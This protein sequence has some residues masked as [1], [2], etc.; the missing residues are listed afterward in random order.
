MAKWDLPRW[1]SGKRLE[2]LLITKTWTKP[3][4]K[5]SVISVTKLG[6]GGYQ[7]Q[8]KVPMIPL[9]A[10]RMA[11]LFH[12]SCPRISSTV[13]SLSGSILGFCSSLGNA[14][15]SASDGAAMSRDRPRKESP[16]WNT[17]GGGR[18]RGGT[19]RV[20]VARRRRRRSGGGRRSWS[21]AGLRGG[22]GSRRKNDGKEKLS[23]DYFNPIPCSCHRDTTVFFSWQLSS[24]PLQLLLIKSKRYYWSKY[25]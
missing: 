9:K 20:Q 12:I 10:L 11:Q 21:A 15:G 1:T 4:T 6:P 2:G 3:Y 22:E 19:G 24:F 5:I 7:R 25:I 17:E 14:A 8:G 13:G 23:N 16:R 18:E